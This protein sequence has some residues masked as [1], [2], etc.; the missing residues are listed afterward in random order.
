MQLLPTLQLGVANHWI[1]LLLYAAALT[2]S[3]LA[4]PKERREWLFA[5]QKQSI[6]GVELLL[7]RLGQVVAFAAIAVICLTPLFQ[8]PPGLTLVG[9]GLYV[10]GM[11]M[12]VASVYYFGRAAAGQ[13]AVDGP[14]R[15][16][17]NP[18]WVGL[19][20]VLLGLA[21]MCASWL[22][23][24]AVGVIAVVYHIQ[25]IEEEKACLAAYGGPYEDYLKTVPRYLLL[26]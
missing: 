6:H 10:A 19:F 11:V 20:F 13:P 16:S 1:L 7:L 5:D 8:A 26:K 23:I 24:A 25:I 2:L 22:L 12:V 9:L 14:Y 21:I 18:Q 3:A 17:R 4:L 15:F